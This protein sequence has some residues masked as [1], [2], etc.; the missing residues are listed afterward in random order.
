MNDCSNEVK[1]LWLIPT[2]LFLGLMLLAILRDIPRVEAHLEKVYGF[3]SQIALRYAKL[4]SSLIY[5]PAFTYLV[6]G[7]WLGETHRIG[8]FGACAFWAL[9]PTWWF[10]GYLLTGA[11]GK[12]N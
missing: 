12:A 6:L 4:I 9:A 10:L 7:T 3:S 8:T 5:L 2:L 1:M 11:R